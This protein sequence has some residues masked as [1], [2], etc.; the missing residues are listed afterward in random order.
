MLVLGGAMLVCVREGAMLVCVREGAMLVCVREGAMLVLF[1]T[2]SPGARRVG[3]G[4]DL[5]SVAR[6]VLEWGAALA[7]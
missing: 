4:A 1:L 5:F 3:V 2:I 6:S 7:P